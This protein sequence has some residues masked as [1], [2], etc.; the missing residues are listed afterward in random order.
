[1]PPQVD[2]CFWLF[3]CPQEPTTSWLISLPSIHLIDFCYS[4]HVFTSCYLALVRSCGCLLA[5]NRAKFIVLSFSGKLKLFLCIKY[6]FS[7]SICRKTHVCM[8]P[9]VQ[10][11]IQLDLDRVHIWMVILTASPALRRRPARVLVRSSCG[12]FD[13]LLAGAD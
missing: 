7:S 13:F 8:K 1:M 4:L 11:E 5:G 10:T 2:T 6:L 3:F 12:F 9:S